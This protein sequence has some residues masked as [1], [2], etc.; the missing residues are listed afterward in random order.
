MPYIH[1]KKGREKRKKKKK[2]ELYSC[3]IICKSERISENRNNHHQIDSFTL[4][5]HQ[6]LCDARE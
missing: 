6:L 1:N 2:T 4:K 5:K 3:I